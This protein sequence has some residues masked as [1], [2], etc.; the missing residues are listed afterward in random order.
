MPDIAQ[1]LVRHSV[2]LAPT[3]ELRCSGCARTLLTGERWHELDGGETLCDLCLARLPEERRRSVR[4]ERVRALARR[5]V[6]APRSRSYRP[7][8]A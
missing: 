1:L 3:S 5:L 4:S 8:A 7:R 2:G 6:V